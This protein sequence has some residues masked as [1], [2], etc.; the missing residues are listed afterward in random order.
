M[1]QSSTQSP[2]SPAGEDIAIVGMACMVPGADTVESFWHNV[3]NKVD[4][5]TDAPPEWAPESFYDPAGAAV[6]RSYTTKGGFLGDLCRF[7]PSKY[8]VPPTNIDG[9]EPDQFIALRCAFEALADAGVPEL[10]LNRSKTSVIIGRGIFVNRGWATVFQRT[11]TV[12]N[13][14]QVLRK[15]EPERTEDDLNLI[16]LEL[17]KSLPPCNADT[18]PGLV[19]SALAG[20]IA[21]KFDLMGPS[22]TIDAACASTLIAVEHG[23]RELRAGRSDAVVAG[24]SQVSTPGPVHAMFCHL[25]ALSRGKIAPFSAEAGGTLL[26]QGCGMIVLKRRSDAER[27]GNRIYALIKAVGVSSDGKGVGLLA[28]RT[29]G[30]Q[31]A[32]S[33]AYEEAGVSPESIGLVEAHGTGIPL[34]DATEIGSLRAIFGARANEHPSVA[35]G[36]VKSMLGHLLPA[37]GVPS[38]IK[39]ALA[40]YH[41]VLPPTL[42]AEQAQTEL[43]LDETCFF[44]ANEPRPWLHHRTDANRRAGINAFGFGGINAHAVLEEYPHDEAQRDDLERHWPSELVVISAESREAL[45]HRLTTL[46]SWLSAAADP[47]LLD[48]AAACAAHAGPSRLA[49][50]AKN[51]PDLIKKLDRAAEMLGQ[52]DRVKIQDRGGIFWQ[53]EP[54]G[55][56]GRVGFMFPG[57]GCQYPNMLAQL[58]RHFPEVRQEFDVTAQALAERGKSLSAVLFPQPA[59]AAQAEAELLRMEY[60][61]ASVTAASRGLFRLLSR[62]G[63]KA[64]AIV[65]HSSGEYASLLA[66]G[67]CGDLDSDRV[68]Q[69]VAEGVDSASELQSSNL[70]PQAVLVSAGGVPQA[71]LDEAVAATNGEVVIAMDNCPNQRILVGSEEA[72]ASVLARIQG[73]GGICQ[74]LDLDRAYHT[75]AFAPASSIVARYIDS[76]ELSA[77]ITEL[78][79]CATADRFPAGSQAIRDLAVQQWSS[80][81][82]FR[83]TIVAMHDAGVRIFIEIG[84]R[85]NLSA[86]AA[87]TLTGRP[88]AVIPLNL[89]NVDDVTQ[90]CTAVGVLV[91]NGV[92]VDVSQLF[93]RRSP[94]HLDFTRPP[95]TPPVREPLLRT[96]LPAFTLSD[97]AFEIWRR[98]P[99]IANDGVTTSH[100]P[101]KPVQPLSIHRTT[102]K[103]QDSNG[104][105][106]ARLEPTMDPPSSPRH[107]ALKEFQSTMQQYLR[108]QEAVTLAY[109]RRGRMPHLESNGSQPSNHVDDSRILQQPSTSPPVVAAPSSHDVH[110]KVLDPPLQNP[111]SRVPRETVSKVRNLPFIESILELKL[112]ERIVAE[113]ELSIA[114]HP[115]LIDHTFFGRKISKEDPNLLALPIMPMVMT[116]ELMAEGAV[117]LFPDATVSVI[118]DVRALGWLTCPGHSRRLRIEAHAEHDGLVHATVLA[119]DVDGGERIATGIVEL[120]PR[121]KTLGPVRFQDLKQNPPPWKPEDVYD[122]FL[123]HGPAFQGILEFEDFGPAGLRCRAETPSIRLLRDYRNEDLILPVA[124]IDTASQVPGLVN[125]NYCA[126]GKWT[127][128][129]FPNTIG[130]LEVSEAACNG[131]PWIINSL[132][133]Q[134]SGKIVSETEIRSPDGDAVLRYL[135]RAEELV[136]FP[137]PLYL[138]AGSPEKTFLAASIDSVFQGIPGIEHCHTCEASGVGDRLL[139]KNHWAQVVGNMVLSA[140]ERIERDRQ[141]LSP[142]ALAQWLLT[143]VARKETIRHATGAVAPRLADVQIEPD[144]AGRPCGILPSGESLQVSTAQHLFFTVAISAPAEQFAGIGLAAEPLR[145]FDNAQSNSSF[146][147]AEL[148]LLRA[149]ASESKEPEHDWLRFGRAAKEAFAKANCSTSRPDSNT[150]KIGAVDAFNRRFS[151]ALARSTSAQHLA[152]A[153]SASHDSAATTTLEQSTA[154]SDVYCRVHGEHALAICLIPRETTY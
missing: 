9:A 111:P 77:P 91:A 34:G 133:D 140:A 13:I 60:A 120:A 114:K 150:M 98:K 14:L 59:A 88:H 101:T 72:I 135:N 148:A 109:A 33:R 82:R 141:K 10:P 137:L 62:F 76:L 22:Y 8:G 121:S 31:L 46:S 53:A 12:E 16:R 15:I 108:T 83:E 11:I 41:R 29:E 89:P 99:A 112:G 47:S 96:D 146:D 153:Q 52:S 18:F 55:K 43:K 75:A 154:T 17:K 42:H 63:I 64:D 97:D 78:W 149:A 27:D 147:A 74:R 21:N 132:V 131:G 79:S 103:Q 138:Y 115:F 93:A 50:V 28:P 105:A 23:I 26:G 86:F 38:L 70:V 24:G 124:L 119:A 130:R 48:V 139:I 102:L 123:Y 126:V 45:I 56:S 136:D 67:A 58:C 94:N 127:V 6:D 69:I 145:P 113:C 36:S 117:S 84:P 81:V 125:A 68:K 4:C 54:L 3:V 1:T 65:G 20:R 37:S 57:E 144:A 100:S 128:I 142:V 32:I 80:P 110:A 66:A 107:A 40:L 87:D 51:V 152:H 92:D 85:G 106:P 44:L 2:K 30:Q 134:S 151:L 35:L 5:V 73:K 104:H 19:H 61:V 71:A 129:A 116:L 122:H 90:L 95:A 143:H 39:T 25:Q 49:I 118:R 7:K